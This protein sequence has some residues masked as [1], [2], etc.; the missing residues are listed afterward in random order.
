MDGKRPITKYYIKST[1]LL[2][3]SVKAAAKKEEGVSSQA[4]SCI[5]EWES[6]LSCLLAE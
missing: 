2:N 4:W 3:S 5:A 6:Q 1:H